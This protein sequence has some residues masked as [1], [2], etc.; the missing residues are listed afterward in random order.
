MAQ[1]LGAALAVLRRL[2][3]AWHVVVRAAL[4][5]RVYGLRAERVA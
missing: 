1:R 3:A 5:A 2:C 4:L